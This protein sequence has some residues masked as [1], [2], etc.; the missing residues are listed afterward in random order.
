M[1][2]YAGWLFLVVTSLLV[3][4]AAFIWGLRSGQ[5]ADQ[6]RARYLPLSKDL[7]DEPLVAAGPRKR[8]TNA[9]ALLLIVLMALAA[10]AAA[11]LMSVK[12]HQIG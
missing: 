6:D 10:F 3:S 11:L 8:K 7:L 1:N 5:F 2:Y 9:T 4:I 12:D